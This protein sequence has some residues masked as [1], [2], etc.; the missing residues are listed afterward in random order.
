MIVEI[1]Y[2]KATDADVE[3]IYALCRALID[4]YED[5]GRIDYPKVLRWVHEK[6]RHAIGEYTVI[7]ADGEKAG[8]YHF[9]KNGD[10]A[11]E[12]DDLYV[13]EPF[14]NQGIGTQ[15]L[16]RCCTAAAEPVSLYVF[17]E[18]HRAVSLYRRMGF[19]IIKAVHET[20]YVM[21]YDAKRGEGK[22]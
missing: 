8:Y 16:R 22:T 4:T 7:Y 9:F 18:N 15:V 10:G 1:T 5:T 11:Y 20:R 6:I 21:L 3:P 2:Q 12:L 14:Q 19:E 13:F 17:K